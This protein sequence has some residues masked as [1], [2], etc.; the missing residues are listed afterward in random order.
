MRFAGSESQAW[1]SLY[2]AED[3]LYV[4]Y[5]GDCTVNGCF[6]DVIFVLIVMKSP[7]PGAATS[8]THFMFC[9]SRHRE[10]HT[11]RLILSKRLVLLSH[12]LLTCM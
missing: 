2:G 11:R 4:A 8:C 10:P 7:T 3:A 9:P 5:I 12:I 1:D 6:F